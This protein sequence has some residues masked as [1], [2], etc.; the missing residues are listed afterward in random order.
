VILSKLLLLNSFATK[1]FKINCERSIMI[2]KNIKNSL[3]MIISALPGGKTLRRKRGYLID[4]RRLS[5][6]GNAKEIFNHYYQVNIWGNDESASGPGSTIQYTENIRQ[7]IPQVAKELGISVILD[8]PCGDYNW[9]RLINWETEISYIGGDIVKPLI[10]RNQKLYGNNWMNF[11]KLDITLDVLPKAD[12]FLCRDCLF[13]LSNCDIM[14]VIDNFLKSDIRF[15]LTSTYPNFVGNYDI[16]SG[17]FRQL[18]LQLP[19]FSFG[20]P[21]RMIDDWIEGY[22]VRKLALWEREALR[23][24]MVF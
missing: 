18:N 8:A 15:I 9:F 23:N 13:H 4:K 20:K 22:P 7:I 17:S 3:R 14:R 5:R 16:P 10:Y 12:L 11:I 24:H 2:K 6:I 21:I 19:P 1:I